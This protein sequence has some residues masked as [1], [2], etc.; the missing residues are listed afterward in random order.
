L[1]EFPFLN[2]D[3]LKMIQAQCY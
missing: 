2:T 1:L 3:K